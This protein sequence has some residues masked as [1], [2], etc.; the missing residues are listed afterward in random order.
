MLRITNCLE[1]IVMQLL[2]NCI[3]SGSLLDRLQGVSENIEG[4]V[5]QI[6][7]V[8][9]FLTARCY[10]PIGLGGLGRSPASRKPKLD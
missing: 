5:L 1:T 9:L 3:R 8:T 6:G 4:A 7:L 2:T 10:A